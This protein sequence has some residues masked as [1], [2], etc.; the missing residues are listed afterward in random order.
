MR[1]SDWSSVVCASDLGHRVGVRIGKALDVGRL[2]IE[3]IVD[4]QLEARLLIHFESE[5]D[6][7]VEDGR[8]TIADVF[9]RGVEVGRLADP[10]GRPGRADAILFSG[11]H[12]IAAPLRITALAATDMPVEL[13]PRTTLE[14]LDGVVV[15]PGYIEIGRAPDKARC[16]NYVKITGG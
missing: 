13:A 7:V 14:R 16:F 5:L 3:Q 10:L 15:Y 2:A 8:R 9:G 1:I 12:A 6:I 11:D 4:A